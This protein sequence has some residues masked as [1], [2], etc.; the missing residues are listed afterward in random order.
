LKLLFL[1]VVSFSLAFGQNPSFEY[2]TTVPFAIQFLGVE[3]RGN[4]LVEDMSFRN[5]MGGRTSAYRVLPSSREHTPGALFVHWYD[6]DSM[7][8][9]R[10]QFLNEAVELAQHGLESL[11]VST[12][13]SNPKFYPNRDVE[14]DYENSVQEG[15]GTQ[16]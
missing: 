1:C 16:A 4:V 2:D 14:L 10:T 3:H 7:T 12:P 9:N 11:L 8:S 13:W 5:L 6:P 15:E